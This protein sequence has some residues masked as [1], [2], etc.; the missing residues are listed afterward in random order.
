V[1]RTSN[2]AEVVPNRLLCSAYAEYMAEL[3]SPQL[4]ETQGG[5][6]SKPTPGAYSTDQGNVTQVCPGFHPIYRIA[7]END[8]SNHTKQFTAGAGTDEAYQ[9]TI[10]TA[11][12]M[13]ATAWRM[14]TD[15][16]F[17]GEVKAEFEKETAKREQA[18][19]K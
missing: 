11:R 16:G 3:G 19:R 4:C 10:L 5:E 6:D 18:E 15:D 9:L 8:A 17:A 14:L 13:A 2:Y 1:S 12:G 7:T